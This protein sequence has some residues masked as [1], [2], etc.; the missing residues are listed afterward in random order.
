MGKNYIRV[1]SI[2]VPS[3]AVLIFISEKVVIND[4][5]LLYRIQIIVIGLPII[6][7]VLGIILA[8][9]IIK[10]IKKRDILY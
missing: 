2:G 8:L 5:L 6:L 1:L 10:S 9:R 4:F 3:C 7:I